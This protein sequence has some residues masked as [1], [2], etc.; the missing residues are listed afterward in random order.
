MHAL[1]LHRGRPKNVTPLTVL[2]KTAAA[3]TCI[4]A[5]I[6]SENLALYKSFTYLLSYLLQSAKCCLPVQFCPSPVYPGLHLHLRLPGVLVQLAS[7][8]QAPLFVAHSSIS[9]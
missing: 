7:M 1:M 3:Q 2:P 9:A 4:C 6:L 5:L 8:L